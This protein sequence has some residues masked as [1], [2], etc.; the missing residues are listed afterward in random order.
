M[1]N[2]FECILCDYKCNRKFLWD[3]HLSTRKHEKAT[4]A[5]HLQNS[6]KAD[7]VDLLTCEGCGR[8]YKQR[9]GLWRHKKKCK[10]LE[11]KSS[12]E[13]N[14]QNIDEMKLLEESLDLKINKALNNPL[15]SMS[16]KSK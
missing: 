4:Q 7:K 9:S 15:N 8:Q 14:I 16:A 3:Q 1:Q 12:N 13:S 6:S 10:I 2:K 5:T 11:N